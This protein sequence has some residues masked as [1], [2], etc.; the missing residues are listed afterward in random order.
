MISICSQNLTYLY[1]NSNIIAYLAKNLQLLRKVKIMRIHLCRHIQKGIVL[2]LAFA[3]IMTS[4]EVSA[5]ENN[6]LQ[7]YDTL[8]HFREIEVSD[9]DVNAV[10]LHQKEISELLAEVK[11]LNAKE[12]ASIPHKDAGQL[13]GY[14]VLLYALEGK[15]TAE[16]ESLFS[17]KQIQAAS[18]R[19]NQEESETEGSMQF[20]GQSRQVSAPSSYVPVQLLGV[21]V[22]FSAMIPAGML[23]RRRWQRE[24]QRRRAEA[25]NA[26]PKARRI[27][28]KRR[29]PVAR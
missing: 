5:A 4:L 20:A 9:T 13:A 15:D 17:A 26:Q 19:I 12:R 23:I 11:K 22:V 6:L 2:F 16:L 27:P 8:D 25:E 24:M 14:F 3:F 21:L 29:T 28:R 10:K 7:I 1:E 18:A